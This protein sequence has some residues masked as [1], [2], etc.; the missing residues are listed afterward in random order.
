MGVLHNVRGA[1]SPIVLGAIAIAS[2]PCRGHAGLAISSS[3]CRIFILPSSHSSPHRGRTPIMAIRRVKRP[4][5]HSNGIKEFASRNRKGAGSRAT[6]SQ[7]SSRKGNGGGKK[8]VKGGEGGR[9]RGDQSRAAGGEGRG[10]TKGESDQY[11]PTTGG[12][13]FSAKASTSGNLMGN[14]AK[15]RYKK[16]DL[17]LIPGGAGRNNGHGGGKNNPKVNG[18]GRR[19]RSRGVRQD[20]VDAQATLMPEQGNGGGGRGSRGRGAKKGAVYAGLAVYSNHFSDLVSMELRHEK[21]VAYERMNTWTPHQLS[22]SGYA[23]QGLVGSRVGK[24]FQEYVIR[25]SLSPH[26]REENDR[27]KP[28]RR[29]LMPY[30]R[31]TAGD[32]IAVSR[33][34]RPPTPEAM[35]NGDVTDAIVL[36]RAPFFLDVVVKKLPEGLAEAGE[37]MRM[38]DSTSLFRLDQFV[39]GECFF[40]V[41]YDR[42]LQAVQAATAPETLSVCPAIRGLV[43]NSL[44][45]TLLRVKTLDR[46]GGIQ[47]GV[48]SPTHTHGMT[49]R[50]GADEGWLRLA[51]EPSAAAPSRGDVSRVVAEVVGNAGLN[52]RQAHAIRKA[53][54]SRVTLIQGPPGTG[55]TRTACNLILAATR[56]RLDKAGLPGR[57]EGKVLA[58]AFSNVAADNLLEGLLRLG[59]KAVR[60]GRPATVRSTLWTATLDSMLERHHEV[61]AAKGRLKIMADEASGLDSEAR[62][63]RG[64]RGRALRARGV[65]LVRQSFADL[66]SAQDKASRE[67]LQGAEVVVLSCIGAGNDAFVRAIG[68][69]SEGGH[70]AIRFSTV[71]IDEAT[72]ATEAAALVPMVR[73]CQQLVLVGDQNQLPPTVMCREAEEAG[74]GTSLFSRLMHTGMEPILLN[75][76]YRMHPA[77]ADFSSRQFYGGEVS[78]EVRPRDRPVPQGFPWPA[79]STPVA[80]IAISNSPWVGVGGRG[81]LERRGGWEFGKATRGEG[82]SSSTMGTSYCNEREANAVA[83]VLEMLLTGEDVKAKDVGIITPYSGQVRLLQDVVSRGH[84]GGGDTASNDSDNKSSSS[85]SSGNNGSQEKRQEVS[86]KAHGPEINSVDGYQGR[87]KEVIILSAVRSN[88]LGKVGFL[89]DWRRLNVAVTRARRGLVVVGDPLTLCRDRHWRAFIRWCERRGAVM[90]EGDLARAQG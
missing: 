66:E 55:K 57:R 18:G 29:P 24:L 34:R 56:L 89:A 81:E 77:I 37:K 20:A 70:S 75:R 52:K 64:P 15:W 46:A 88:H 69:D 73:G 44:Y 27:G 65:D 43:V 62:G 74:L 30:H 53:L 50:A 71:V 17:S 76:Q 31:F 5:G 19:Q 42:M 25:F 32:V 87:E 38:G 85:S 28:M 4:Q 36:K 35:D 67:I 8:E 16:V 68:G 33:G 82:P 83:R 10:A 6:A 39:N 51:Q 49:D 22:E 84:S 26:R 14:P 41:S 12:G 63:I 72:Q 7:S 1:F 2:V 80:F 9:K 40:R 11:R 90:E 61:A 54:E 13:T 45:P 60:V 58:T 48:G 86:S 79:P 47:P 23:V 59:L 3:R 21:E 78:S